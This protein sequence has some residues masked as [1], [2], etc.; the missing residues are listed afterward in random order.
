MKILSNFSK[1]Q[2]WATNNK[3]LRRFYL[4][5]FNKN[6]LGEDMKIIEYISYDNITVLFL[7]TNTIVEKREYA[8]FLS[9]QIRNPEYPT[10]CGVGYIGSGEYKSF[11]NG[12][13]TKE[14]QC[15]RDMIRRVYGDTEKSKFYKN[16]SISKEW[17]NFQNFAK[18]YKDNYYQIDNERMELDKDIIYKGNKIYSPDTCIFVPQFINKIFTKNNKNRGNLPIGVSKFKNKYKVSCDGKY[19]GLFNTPE[20]AFNAYK[21]EK[22]IYIKEIAELYK[23]KIPKILYTALIN[24]KVEF[25][26]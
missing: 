1:T 22:E 17:Y 16:C 14:Y 2:K 12:H 20:D 24:Y 19:I 11:I 13:I 10:V 21:Q 26:D 6:N 7:D 4:K 8:K 25:F 23:D 18:W 9:G 15:W 3:Y 5:I